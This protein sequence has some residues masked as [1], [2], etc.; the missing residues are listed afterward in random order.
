MLLDLEL[1]FCGLSSGGLA[2]C[3]TFLAVE[4]QQCAPEE[5]A[6]DN[7]PPCASQLLSK[8]AHIYQFDSH[9]LLVH[10]LTQCGSLDS[11]RAPLN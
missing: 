1:P 3:T 6:H 5:L 9:V 7:H 8:L 2:P 11:I 10:D 4:R